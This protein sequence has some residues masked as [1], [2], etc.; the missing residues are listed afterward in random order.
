[1][2]KVT[3]VAVMVVVTVVVLVQQRAAE[4]AQEVLK[5]VVMVEVWLGVVRVAAVKVAVAAMVELLEASRGMVET[6][7]TPV[8]L[9]VL[10]QRLW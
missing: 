1:M 6:E 8:V 2:A 9:V 5:E 3:L 7:G 10:Q 4:G